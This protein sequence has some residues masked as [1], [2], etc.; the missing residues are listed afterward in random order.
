[1]GKYKEIVDEQ[2]EKECH[3]TSGDSEQRFPSINLWCAFLTG[4]FDENDAL[5]QTGSQDHAMVANIFENKKS[6]GC[7][8]TFP[9]TILRFCTSPLLVNQCSNQDSYSQ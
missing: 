3:R 7:Y 8:F 6:W 1:M 4:M 9:M 2:W 5:F